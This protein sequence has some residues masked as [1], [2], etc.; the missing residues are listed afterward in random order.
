MQGFFRGGFGS[1]GFFFRFYRFRGVSDGRFR[2]FGGR[3]LRHRLSLVCLVFYFFGFSAPFFRLGLRRLDYFTL[4]LFHFGL[5]LSAALLRLG[6]FLFCFYRLCGFFLGRHGGFFRGNGLF[7]RCFHRCFRKRGLCGTFFLRGFL[8][9]VCGFRFYGVFLR[10][11]RGFRRLFS[12]LFR[13]G[14]FRRGRFRPFRRDGN[15]RRL[16]LHG[17]GQRAYVCLEAHLARFFHNVERRADP[18]LYGVVIPRFL[19]E[20]LGV[21]L[22]RRIQKFVPFI[23]ARSEEL[24]DNRFHSFRF[25]RPRHRGRLILLVLLFLCVFVVFVFHKN[26]L[27]R[28]PPMFFPL[29]FPVRPPLPKSLA[30]LPKKARKVI[31]TG[32]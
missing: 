5:G 7:L 27:R 4:F 13:S 17:R 6:L 31:R 10:F 23:G 14:F 25:F 24:A 16:R 11:P 20:T 22:G 9:R 2:L 15:L 29:F 12:G 30:L 26:T 1:C 28:G 3:I 32:G 8:F 18:P 21:N 19:G